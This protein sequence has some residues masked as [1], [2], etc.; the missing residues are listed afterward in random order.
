VTPRPLAPHPAAPTRRSEWCLA[1]IESSLPFLRRQLMT[2]LTTSGLSEDDSYDLL[3]AACEAASNAIEHAQD[4]P[5]P[6]FD[7]VAEIS[8]T[9][10]VVTI[11]DHGQ[12]LA[13]TVSAFRGR[14][15]Q[16][17][18][19]LAD[20]T[21]TTSATGTTVTIRALG[22]VTAAAGRTEQAS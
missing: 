3:L 19:L 10:V 13:P 8:P 20:T 16:M 9:T 4:P 17:M 5:E 14:G 12:W 2:L 15:L 1:N 21:V 7:V 18:R 22:A 6:F 11:R